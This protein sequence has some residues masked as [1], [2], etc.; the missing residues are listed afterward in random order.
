MIIGACFTYSVDASGIMEQHARG[1]EEDNSASER[2]NRAKNA[3]EGKQYGTY[4]NNKD[5][6]L[7]FEKG[8]F[9]YD[10]GEAYTGYYW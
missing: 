9:P 10:P 8:F 3:D 2:K 1:L 5:A 7:Q 6:N 4:T